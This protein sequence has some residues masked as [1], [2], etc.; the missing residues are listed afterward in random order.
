LFATFSVYS[1]G[2][3]LF[4]SHHASTSDIIVSVYGLRALSILWV[5]HG[6]R[7]QLYANFPMMN[8]IQFRE[9][10]GAGV[11]SQHEATDNNVNYSNGTTR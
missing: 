3:R 10:S 4:E 1:N 9:V 7:Q 6:H 8:K 5:M 11:E 2:M